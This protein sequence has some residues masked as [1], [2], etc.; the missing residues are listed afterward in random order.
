MK[1]LIFA[2]IF[3]G[4]GNFTYGQY[5][6]K[7][8]TSKAEIALTQGKLDIA[9]AEIDEA[10][11]IDNKGKVTGAAKNW[12]TKG[13]IYKALYLD[14]STAFKDLVD[15]EEAL[16]VTMEAFKKVKAMEKESSSY[17]I[18]TDQEVNVLYGTIVNKGAEAYNEDDLEGAYKIFMTVLIV[19]PGDTTALMYGG[20]AAQQ[21]EMYDEAIACFQ[22]LA[23]N[24]DANIDAYKSMIYLYR[25]EKEDMESVLRVV[26]QGLEAFPQNSLLT[27][28]KITSLI[29]MEREEEAKAELETAINDDPTNSLYYY[30][31]GYLYDS[32]EDTDNAMEQYKKAIELNPEYYEANYNL[33]VVYYNEAREI[34]SE[35]NAMT[36]ADWEKKEVEYTDRAAKYFREALPYFEK[37]VEINDEELQLLE[38]LAGVYLRLRM[39]EKGEALDKKIK[40]LTGQ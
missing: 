18:F 35:L 3:I 30:F 13:K 28:E 33:G 8:K 25:T 11:K 7:G 26:D 24:G 17:V 23:D 36:L 29:I 10:F 37:A 2:I 21:A 9:K 27:Q 31:L 4:I 40:A 15:K 1:K 14:D 5:V 38:T 16:K 19:Q 20:Y 22:T 6:P 34:I 39:T 12:F 32:Q